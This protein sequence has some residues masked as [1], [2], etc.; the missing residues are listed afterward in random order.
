[1][2]SKMGFAAPKNDNNPTID[3]KILSPSELEIATNLFGIVWEKE[4][5]RLEKRRRETGV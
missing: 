5:A 2:Y 4:S 1:M 3:L